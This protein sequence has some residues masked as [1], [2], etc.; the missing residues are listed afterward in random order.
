MFT[1]VTHE[2]E[3]SLVS[4]DPY[5]VLLATTFQPLANRANEVLKPF[6]QPLPPECRDLAG[7]FLPLQTS[8]RPIIVFILYLPD[9]DTTLLLDTKETL[10]PDL[11]IIGNAGLFVHDTDS[12]PTIY[13][14]P[15][16]R[17][18]RFRNDNKRYTSSTVGLSD[19][20]VDIVQIGKRRSHVIGSWAQQPGWKLL[21][22]SHFS[23]NESPLSDVCEALHFPETLQSLA[24]DQHTSYKGVRVIDITSDALQ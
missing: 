3:R 10:L 19:I 6:Q 18:M 15:T 8:T 4:V 12:Q 23:H 9:T 14:C 11:T 13:I 21:F 16:I 7:A 17:Q 1:E 5:K 20:R 24:F 2:Q 22:N